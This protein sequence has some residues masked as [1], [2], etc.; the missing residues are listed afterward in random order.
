MQGDLLKFVLVNSLVFAPLSDANL[1]C[2]WY[3]IGHYGNYTAASVF[4]NL[5][6]VSRSHAELCTPICIFLLRS[7][8]N[9]ACFV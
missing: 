7:H 1:H 8:A 2:S 4:F 9:L 5:C 6:V 3:C